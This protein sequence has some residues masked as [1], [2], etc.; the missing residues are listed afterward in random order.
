MR[1]SRAFWFDALAAASPAAVSN[2]FA[3]ALA[4]ASASVS[5]GGSGGG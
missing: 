2:R 5:Y 3:A 1:A 4:A